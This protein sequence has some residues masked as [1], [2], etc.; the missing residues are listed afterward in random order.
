MW[1][2]T[3]NLNCSLCILYNV[4]CLNVGELAGAVCD[5]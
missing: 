3:Q 1:Q 2:D 4:P 5:M